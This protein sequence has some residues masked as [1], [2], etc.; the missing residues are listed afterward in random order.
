MCVYIYIYK[1]CVY[2][3][4]R[5]ADIIEM[6]QRHADSRGT[7]GAAGEL[8]GKGQMG[9]ALMGSQQILVFLTEG[10]FGYSR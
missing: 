4:L 9:S 7:T 2:S 5:K 6:V 8:V 1:V 3:L 10:L